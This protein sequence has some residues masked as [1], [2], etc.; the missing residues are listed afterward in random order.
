MLFIHGGKDDFV[1][2]DM[3]YEV[4]DACPTTK[5]LYIV[6]EAGHAQAKDYDVEDYWN[7]VFDFIDQNIWKEWNIM[8]EAS[9]IQRV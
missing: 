7:K 4:Y 6:K 3:V 9:V 5:E 8:S 1:P 2:V